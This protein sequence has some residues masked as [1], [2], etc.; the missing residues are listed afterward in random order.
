MGQLLLDRGRADQA[1]KYFDR[2][3]DG[4]IF[5]VVRFWIDPLLRTSGVDTWALDQ[6]RVTV[7]GAP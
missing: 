1:M 2:C 4:N 5:S 6:S 7:S 3:V